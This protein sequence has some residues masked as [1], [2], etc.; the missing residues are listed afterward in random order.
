[1]DS[2]TLDI[3]GLD[4]NNQ[5]TPIPVHLEDAR[6]NPIFIGEPPKEGEEDTR[7]PLILMV[8]G[9]FSDAYRVID[10]KVRNEQLAKNQKRGTIQ[11][12]TVQELDEREERYHVACITAWPFSKNG[13]ALPI[14]AVNWHAML[15]RQPQWRAQIAQAIT[16]YAD[17][18]ARQSAS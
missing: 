5:N 4:P 1:M 7:V 6:H 18:F 3:D 11:P 9:E 13:K 2:N 17:F 14:T 8:V 12:L 10:E 16:G 15:A